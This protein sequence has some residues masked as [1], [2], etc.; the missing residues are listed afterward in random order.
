MTSEL[1]FTTYLAQVM[2]AEHMEWAGRL[3]KKLSQ[4]LLSHMEMCIVLVINF[5]SPGEISLLGNSHLAIVLWVSEGR[6]IKHHNRAW[7]IYGLW[8]FMGL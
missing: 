3:Q 7:W 2:A 5:L 8:G 6:G 1:G 4:L